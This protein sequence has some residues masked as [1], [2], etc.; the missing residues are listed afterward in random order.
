MH[1]KKPFSPFGQTACMLGMLS[2]QQLRVLIFQQKRLQ[3]KFGTILLEKN[4]LKDYELQ[5]LLYQFECHN[6]NIHAQGRQ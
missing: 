5:E 2:E 3:K 4:L 6:D 1:N